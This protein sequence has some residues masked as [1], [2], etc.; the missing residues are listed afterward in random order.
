MEYGIMFPSSTVIFEVKKASVKSTDILNPISLCFLPHVSFRKS[1]ILH[2]CPCRTLFIK[3]SVNTI[4]LLHTTY[5]NI[6]RTHA[7]ITVKAEVSAWASCPRQ[8]ARVFREPLWK[9]AQGNWK[10]P[11]LL[12]T[13]R[14]SNPVP[15]VDE[16][17]TVWPS[18]APW[19]AQLHVGVFVSYAC[20]S[21]ADVGDKRQD[22]LAVWLERSIST[23]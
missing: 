7:H 2:H 19:S 10:I 16:P 5:V 20:N 13:V 8:T 9:L 15:L 1:F 14:D 22:R 18:S 23:R 11:L 21:S 4:R 3:L 12:F 6:P 17:Q